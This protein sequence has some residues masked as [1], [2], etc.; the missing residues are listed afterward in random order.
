MAQFRILCLYHNKHKIMQFV[1][2]V[3]LPESEQMFNEIADA[4]PCCVV[5][6]QVH[7]LQ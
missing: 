4:T 1:D 5:G 3:K 2:I 6:D 7:Y